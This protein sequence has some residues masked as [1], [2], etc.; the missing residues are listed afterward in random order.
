MTSYP[1]GLIQFTS[2]RSGMHGDRLADDEAIV[3][4]FADG[5][6]GVCVTDL[7]DFVRVEPDLRNRQNAE[8]S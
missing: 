3:D 7:G 8:Q 5:L 2:S 6:S 1:P 4:E